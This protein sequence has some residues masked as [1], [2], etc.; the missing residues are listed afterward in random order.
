MG[1]YL[2]YWG[3]KTGGSPGVQ[4]QS[5]YTHIDS[6]KKTTHLP[7]KK[8]RNKAAPVLTAWPHN[9]SKVDL[10]TS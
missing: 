7:K 2:H 1:L 8:K 4:R 3:D 6:A 9:Q 5:G 10:V